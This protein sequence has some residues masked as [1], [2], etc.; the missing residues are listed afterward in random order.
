MQFQSRNRLVVF[1]V[2][3]IGVGGLIWWNRSEGGSREETAG[4]G[5]G[6]VG[7]KIYP[8]ERRDSK[9]TVAAAGSDSEPAKNG[10]APIGLE[11]QLRTILDLPGKPDR[12]QALRDLGGAL[13]LHDPPAAA[14]QVK[15]ILAEKGQETGDAYAYVFGFMSDYAVRS[16]AAAAA[17]AEEL[18]LD[19]KFGAYALVAQHW[20]KADLSASTTWA[21]GIPDLSLRTATLRRIGQELESSGEPKAAAAWAQRLA[22]APDAAHHTEMISRLWAKGDAPGAFQWSSQLEDSG[23]RT[24]AVVA[25][26]GIV[27]AQDPRAAGAWIQEFPQGELRNQAAIAVASRWS[28]YDPEAAARWVAGL[29]DQNLLETVIPTVGRRWLQKDREGATEWIRLAPI[30]KKIQE[31]VLGP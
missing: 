20:A 15:R 8:V 29:G 22:A 26:A 14:I 9:P 17:W 27:A 5:G 28:E 25:I 6:Q 2:V 4:S 30:S 31:Y 1:A 23:R 10:S 13:A 18:P 19:L 7:K 12:Q 24:S 16:P 3:V 11:K 21:E